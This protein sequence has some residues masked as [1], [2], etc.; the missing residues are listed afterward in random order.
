MLRT[1][2]QFLLKTAARSLAP[3][4]D[5]QLQDY[6]ASVHGTGTG[7]IGTFSEKQALGVC[8]FWAAVRLISEMSCSFPFE[9]QERIGSSG[10]WET[11]HGH[12]L[13]TF[14]NDAP[15]I[16]QTGIVCHEQRYLHYLMHGHSPTLL[17][18]DPR[19]GSPAALWPVH[20]SAFSRVSDPLRGLMYR[21]DLVGAAETVDRSEVVHMMG[22]S[23]DGL[24]AL[25][26]LKL[27]A[28]NLQLAQ[29]ARGQAASY[30]TN[31]PRPGMV[32]KAP[33][34]SAELFAAFEEKMNKAYSGWNAGKAMI[35]DS[36][37]EIQDYK[38]SFTDYQLL[39]LLAANDKDIGEK[40]FRLP[41]TELKGFERDDWLKKYV[42]QPFVARDEAELTRKL[43]RSSER[44]RFRIRRNMDEL[45]R[46]DIKTRM[47]AFRVGVMAGILRINEVRGWMNLEPDAKGNELY[48]PQSVY[49]KPGTTPTVNPIAAPKKRSRPAETRSETVDPRFQAVLA[50]VIDG[51]F[52]REVHAATRL[53]KQPAEWRSEIDQFYAKHRVVVAEKG[54]PLGEAR[55]QL[56]L[57]AIG[58]HQAVLRELSDP[59]LAAVASRLTE[60]WSLEACQLATRLLEP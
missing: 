17:R 28:S 3:F 38:M 18:L 43:L 26:P 21:F 30:F 52:Q 19:D 16:E 7:T 27:F 53:A 29:G 50:G 59:D 49:G 35:V 10:L 1:L 32:V 48:L 37:V 31:V 54:K 33:M 20:P 40:I 51:L 15:N 58:Q 46:G 14:L 4:M 24:T 9:V 57:D 55:T 12:E 34:M 8:S 47:E 25:S 2:G 60:T 36:R 41:P 23:L 45:M 39:E 44:G 56:V 42:F 6:F 13:E 22:P 11:R 5:A